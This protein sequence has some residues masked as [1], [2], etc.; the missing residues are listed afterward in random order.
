MADCCYSGRK[1]HH[2]KDLKKKLINRMSRIAGQVRGIQRMIDEDVYCDDVLT[3]I[4]AVKSALNGVS[5][6]LFEAHLNSC[7]VE[8]IQSG[9]V[10]I[11]DELKQTVNRMINNK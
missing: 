7:I 10:E 8:Q 2:P 3:Q 1:A 11:M 4:A 9:S 5:K 6:Q